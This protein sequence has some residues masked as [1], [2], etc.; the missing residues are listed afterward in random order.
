MPAEGMDV[1]GKVASVP[2]FLPDGNLRAFND[3]ARF[4]GDERAGKS[5]AKWGK[6]LKAVVIVDSGAL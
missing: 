4:I 1:V 2:V 3:L 6:P 5:R